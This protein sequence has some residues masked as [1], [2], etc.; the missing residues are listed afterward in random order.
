MMNRKLEKLERIKRK[1]KQK[2]KQL[3]L[4]KMRQKKQELSDALKWALQFLK[5]VEQVKV[6]PPRSLYPARPKPARRKR[7][8]GPGAL[9]IRNICKMKKAA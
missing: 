9:C 4:Q 5:G 8:H 6:P 2:Q 1:R 3:R 7:K